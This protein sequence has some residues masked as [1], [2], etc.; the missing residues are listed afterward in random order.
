[1]NEK[2]QKPDF[3]SIEKILRPLPGFQPPTI[4]FRSRMLAPTPQLT[5]R[6]EVICKKMNCNWENAPLETRYNK[7]SLLH[8]LLKT[9]IAQSQF[10]EL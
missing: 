5:V 7:Y 10:L 9:F 8:S 3:F 4:V 2:G 1:M 6:N